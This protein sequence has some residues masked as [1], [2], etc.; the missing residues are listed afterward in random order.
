MERSIT[1]VLRQLI[2]INNE[3]ILI[4]EFI[5]NQVDKNAATGMLYQQRN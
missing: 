5:D 4:R 2:R 1:H 3:I